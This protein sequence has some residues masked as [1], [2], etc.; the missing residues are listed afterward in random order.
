[1]SSPESPNSAPIGVPNG[2]EVTLIGNDEVH[3]LERRAQD[4][5]TYPVNAAEAAVLD[6]EPEALAM[7]EGSWK[8]IV[9]KV[10]QYR[11]MTPGQLSASTGIAP[12]Q[13]EQV[14]KGLQSRGLVARE[15]GEDGLYDVWPHNRTSTQAPRENPSWLQQKTGFV[16][17]QIGKQAREFVSGRKD[18]VNLLTGRMTSQEELDYK[19]GEGK[20]IREGD[21]A[22]KFAIDEVPSGVVIKTS[23]VDG[24]DSRIGKDNLRVSL[25]GA[26]S[27][28]VE[29]REAPKDLAT[30]TAEADTGDFRSNPNYSGFF[31]GSILNRMDQMIAQTVPQALKAH[32]AGRGAASLMLSAEA[33][34]LAEGG[35]APDVSL[36]PQ[37]SAQIEREVRSSIIRQFVGEDAPQELVDSLDNAR[38]AWRI[39]QIQSG[40][41]HQPKQE[42]HWTTEYRERVAQER[43]RVDEDQT[44]TEPI[45]TVEEEQEDTETEQPVTAQPSAERTS[46]SNNIDPAYA[47][48]F[49][50]H[51]VSQLNDTI[52]AAAMQSLADRGVENPT[53]AEKEEALERSERNVLAM[54]VDPSMPF[55]TVR[56]LQQA[57]H[58]QRARQ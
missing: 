51:A 12:D 49:E 16:K 40:Q 29:F 46:A 37:D 9:S 28:Y 50:G 21:D 57:L 14:F 30:I 10:E 13:A 31:D 48:Y 5:P 45:E 18:A 6:Q 3:V 4:E 23:A 41:P 2:P 54:Q 24:A 34:L 56:K 32:R 15:P 27:P 42:A 52:E 58:A 53:E 7:S 25:R 11:V 47:G 19:R 35:F 22:E 20:N 36:S 1:M 43:E 55:D 38:K 17:S 44:P 8:N 26:T 33:G 39:A